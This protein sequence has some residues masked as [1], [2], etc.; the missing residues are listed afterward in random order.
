MKQI[1]WS[2]LS[3]ALVLLAGCVVTS[4]Y[5]YYQQKDLIFDPALVGVW[6]DPAKTND[7]KETWTFEK[8]G[9]QSYTWTVRD[10]HKTNIFTTHLF[11]LG[12][13]KF[14]DA[15]P[16]ERHDYATP[17]HVLLRVGQIEPQ[18]ELR[19]LSYDWLAKLVA[20]K[21]KAIRHIVVPKDA[22]ADDGLITLTADTAEL[23]KFI[24]KHL[25]NT[26]AWGEPLVMK[27]P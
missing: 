4:I 17:A 22:G 3:L 14:L 23:Q 5:P 16:R 8:A 11:R 24:R 25:H 10:E 18:L 12:D 20:A 1:I 26:N 15:L 21:P 9:A 6:S 13:V 2:G 19:V 27:K 7:T